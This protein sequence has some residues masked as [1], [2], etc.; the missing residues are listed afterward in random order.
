MGGVVQDPL[1]DLNEQKSIS[2]KTMDFEEKPAK[3]TLPLPPLK[4][5]DSSSDSSEEEFDYRNAQNFSTS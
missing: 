1:Y 3:R 4:T 2:E 5:D